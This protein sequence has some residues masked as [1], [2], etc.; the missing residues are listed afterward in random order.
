[1]GMRMECAELS[2]DNHPYFWCC[3]YHPEFKSYPHSP[4]RPFLGLLLAAVGEFEK[5]LPLPQDGERGVI[6]QKLVK[7]ALNE[8]SRSPFP[9]PNPKFNQGQKKIKLNG[10]NGA[11]KT[12]TTI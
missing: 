12:D 4:S 10:V 5:S 3:Q 8:Q 1:M 9:S 7:H 6:L 2:K 11:F